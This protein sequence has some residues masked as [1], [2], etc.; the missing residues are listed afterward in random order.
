MGTIQPSNVASLVNFPE[1]SSAWVN[2]SDLSLTVKL[3]VAPTSVVTSQIDW[4]QEAWHNCP[5][6]DDQSPYPECPYLAETASID[7]VARSISESERRRE[8]WLL[9]HY[10][11]VTRDGKDRLYSPATL[12]TLYFGGTSWT[13]YCRERDVYWACTFEDL[14]EAGKALYQAVSTA[15]PEAK[16]H[17][18]T[19]LLQNRYGVP[20]MGKD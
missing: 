2:T 8:E 16:L 20:G 3:L 4:V 1:L 11:L 10:N 14:T 17:L 13:G 18:R 19:F 6:G 5:V 9:Q 15:Y 7:E 12:A